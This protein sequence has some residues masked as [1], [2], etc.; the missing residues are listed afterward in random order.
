MTFLSH[1]VFAKKVFPVTLE[2]GGLR[3]PPRDTAGSILNASICL[4]AIRVHRDLRKENNCLS[5]TALNIYAINL[6]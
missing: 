3:A 5:S 4:L 6:C 1:L 2:P